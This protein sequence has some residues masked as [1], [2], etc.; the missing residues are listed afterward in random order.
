MSLCILSVFAFVAVLWYDYATRLQEAKNVLESS[1]SDKFLTVL[2]QCFR[3][4]FALQLHASHRCRCDF[5]GIRKVVAMT[6]ALGFRITIV[7][8]SW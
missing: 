3:W 5:A 1:H 6:L 7:V 8:L 4:T 2:S